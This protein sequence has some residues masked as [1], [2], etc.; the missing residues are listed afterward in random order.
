MIR[1][2]F[3]SSNYT[4]SSLTVIKRIQAPILIR[5][6]KKA[7]QPSSPHACINRRIRTS[8]SLLNNRFKTECRLLLNEI[9]RIPIKDADASGQQ[10]KIL[11]SQCINHLWICSLSEYITLSTY[12]YL[13]AVFASN[14]A[15][16]TSKAKKIDTASALIEGFVKMFAESIVHYYTQK[17]ALEDAFES[18]IETIGEGI[19]DFS[20]KVTQMFRSAKTHILDGVHTLQTRAALE[21]YTLN[22]IDMYTFIANGSDE[23]C[24]MCI[25]LNGAHFAIEDAEAGVN[26]PPMHPNCSCSITAYPELPADIN[27]LE[28]LG[29][30]IVDKLK[31]EIQGAVSD[32]LNQLADAIDDPIAVLGSIWNV[33]AGKAVE[34]YCGTFTTITLDG[35]EYR[36]RLDSFSA[37]SIGPDGEFIKPENLLPKD[38]EMLGL[39]KQRDSLTKGSDERKE[40]EVKIDALLAENNAS[41]K[42]LLSVSPKRQYSFYVF[43]GDVTDQLHSYM[44]QAETTYAAMHEKSWIE[45]LPDFYQLVRNSGEMDLKNQS[46]WQHSAYIFDGEVV[47][48]DALGN[49]N[50]GYFGRHCNIPE[51]VLLGAA[52]VA[53]FMAGTYEWEFWF[54]FLDDPRDND[55]VSQGMEIYEE[56]H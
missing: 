21:W 7:V 19:E 12:I 52:G 3:V 49:I 16:S 46:E 56:T 1:K 20:A 35:M 51:I 45:N 23:S 29:D 27:V 43:G 42:T 38:A 11:F 31:E 48:Q 36:I 55:R 47:D 8:Q 44:Q 37:V 30:A 25:S 6:Y 53:Q 2:E 15:E 28:V 5:Q 26:L 17:K 24:E 14:T 50:Y 13:N 39:M 34:D 54:T 33:L 22:G 40:I 18:A 4:T 10:A 41:G 32:G 9:K